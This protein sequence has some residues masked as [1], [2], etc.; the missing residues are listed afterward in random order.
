MSMRVALRVALAAG[1]LCLSIIAAFQRY[2]G[3][4]V[5]D[6][7]RL[8]KDKSNHAM[9]VPFPRSDCMEV[10]HG[11]GMSRNSIEVDGRLIDQGSLKSEI[12]NALDHN[13]TTKAIVLI[14]GVSSNNH[15]EAEAFLRSA[16]SER[17]LAFFLFFENSTYS[18][19]FKP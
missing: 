17:G 13:A 15:E 5:V 6:E 16:A 18:L 19:E 14:I 12:E 1:V 4:K 10:Y 2:I 9:I 3:S 8:L 11:I 7:G